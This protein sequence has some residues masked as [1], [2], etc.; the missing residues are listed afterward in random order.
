MRAGLAVPATLAAAGAAAVGY[1]WGFERKSFRLRRFDVPVLPP[2]AD[3]LRVLHLSDLHLTADQPW[4][5][6]WVH[7]VGA[8]DR[9]LVVDTG[10]NLAA[11]DAIPAVLQA[12]EPLLTRPGAF[13]PGS[14]D[15]F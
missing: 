8:R 5:V 10:D 6:E 9:N 12:L 11:P 7:G 3:P 15:W 13:V 4:K 1:A 14:N 2:G